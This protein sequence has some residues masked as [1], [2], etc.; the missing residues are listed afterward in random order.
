MRFATFTLLFDYPSL[1]IVFQLRFLVDS[2][3]R[4]VKMHVP[5]VYSVL[6]SA[7]LCVFLKSIFTGLKTM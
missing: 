4:R 6:I 7:K 3:Q 1:C 5:F 2:T